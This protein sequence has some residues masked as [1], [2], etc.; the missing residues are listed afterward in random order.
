MIASLAN[1]GLI[2]GSVSF[3]SINAGVQ[4]SVFQIA[5]DQDVG[6]AQADAYTSGSTVKIA[7]MSASM[8]GVSH[9]LRSFY[10]VTSAKALPPQM[11]LQSILTDDFQ[12]ASLLQQALAWIIEHDPPGT[13]GLF[14]VGWPLHGAD[15]AP[16]GTSYSGHLTNKLEKIQQ[17]TEERENTQRGK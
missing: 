6:T 12:G 1:S 9:Y 3:S 2:S 15:G 13:G 8:E 5:L 16:I 14:S 4:G 17:A 11:Q 7:G 10:T